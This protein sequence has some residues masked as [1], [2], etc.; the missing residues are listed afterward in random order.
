MLNHKSLRIA[1]LTATLALAAHADKHI[2]WGNAEITLDGK[3]LVIAGLQKE[4]TITAEVI[5]GHGTTLRITK[6]SGLTETTT[7][8]GEWAPSVLYVKLLVNGEEV[9]LPQGPEL[10]VSQSGSSPALR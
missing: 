6:S 3:N 1:A 4:A 5:T 9:A 8:R 2:R 7:F 10:L